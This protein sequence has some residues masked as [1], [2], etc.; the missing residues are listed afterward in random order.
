MHNI[1]E[2]SLSQKNKQFKNLSSENPELNKLNHIFTNAKVVYLYDGFNFDAF[3]SSVKIFLHNELKQETDTKNYGKDFT[4]IRFNSPK[5]FAGK[6][7]VNTDFLIIFFKTGRLLYFDIIIAENIDGT[8]KKQTNLGLSSLLNDSHKKEIT[9]FIYET[10][11]SNYLKKNIVEKIDFDNTFIEKTHLN[12]RVFIKNITEGEHLL[13]KLNLSALKTEKQ[14]KENNIY[15]ST[16]IVTEEST[17]V[18]GF[19]KAGECIFFK[20]LEDKFEIKKRITKNLILYNDIVWQPK[21]KNSKLFNFLKNIQDYENFDR[22]REIARLNY[23]NKNYN[24]A[25]RLI[26]YIKCKESSPINDLLLLIIRVKNDKTTIQNYFPENE[27]KIISRKLLLSDNAKK[28]INNILNRWQVSYNEKTFF[29]ELFVETADNPDEKR[30]IMPLYETIRTE[31]KK[32]NKD[33]INQTVFDINYADF[34]IDSDKKRRAIKILNKLMKHLPDE[35][36]SDILPPQNLNL[37]S[38]ES[39]QLLKIKILNLLTLAKGKNKSENEIQKLFQLQPL[40]KNNLVQLSEAKNDDLK[41]KAEKIN[42]LLKKTGLTNISKEVPVRKYNKIPENILNA[43][44]RHPATN[45]KGSF[46]SV[47]KW[48]SKIKADDYSSL[49][50]YA[51]KIDESNYSKLYEIFENIQQ[52]F[53]I[54]NLEF[55]ISRGEKSKSII[56]YEGNPPFIIIGQHHL[57][58]NSGLFLNYRE[59]Q[60]SIASEIAHIFFKH[61][62]ISS[63][64]VWRGVADKGV[65]LLD[66]LLTVVPVAGL[67]G[68]SIQN[69]QKLNRLTNILKSSNHIE[70]GKNIYNAAVRLSEYYSSTFK[71]DSK[72]EKEQK[73]LAASRLMQFTADKAGLAICGSIKSAVRTIFLTGKYNF[74]FFE[75]AEK[76]SLYEFLL[77]VNRN[78]SYKNQNIALR[79]AHLF[80]F[81]V[82]DEYSEIRNILLKDE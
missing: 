57:D 79:I 78:G 48:I 53:G 77:K 46:H 12:E 4:E 69:S 31:F 51:E 62:R 39:G 70:K 66:A 1:F 14:D 38:S 20:K 64:D 29:L 18:F 73:L 17:A 8:E 82:S 22:I 68:K 34:L 75:E 63:K 76:S 44:L 26:S 41:S 19:N 28:D 27:F 25:I 11:Y 15:N 65:T 36:I 60:F 43:K 59:L 24:T 7:N 42:I 67:A 23:I 72:T 2:E 49:K 54:E 5:S 3:T 80:S 32:K 40:N 56:G 37:S 47:Q 74:G 50:E 81:Y 33:L 30:K 21:R 45:K 9:I 61:S 52:I 13:V 71:P 10:V 35:T 6:I 16:F 55:Y 58:I